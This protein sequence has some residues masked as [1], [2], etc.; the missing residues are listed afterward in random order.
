[1]APNANGSEAKRMPMLKTPSS[2]AFIGINRPFLIPKYHIDI[3]QQD[4][5]R[6]RG[7]GQ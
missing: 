2:P 1:M 5:R 4:N 7:V 6:I 3:A